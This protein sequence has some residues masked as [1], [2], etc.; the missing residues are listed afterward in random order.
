MAKAENKDKALVNLNQWN[1]KSEEEK[2]TIALTVTVEELKKSKL[3]LNKKYSKKKGGEK[4]T[5][6]KKVN[7]K[8]LFNKNDPKHAWKAKAP[9]ENES[10]TKI[11]D[12]T[13][14]TWC[15]HY[16]CWRQHKPTDCRLQLNDQNMKS[17]SATPV[18][19]TNK[20]KTLHLSYQAAVDRIY[21]GDHS[22]T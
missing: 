11:V 13:E 1:V 14:W 9:K 12:G 7:K 15:P 6:S 8:K 19:N 4:E 16:K 10:Q 2:Q 3:Q 21:Q 18:P 17:P 5:F 20:D 22:D